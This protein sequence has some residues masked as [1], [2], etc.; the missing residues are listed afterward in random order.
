MRW[1]GSSAGTTGR[2]RPWPPLACL[3]SP[4]WP[5][6]D[7]PHR[8]N[9][10]LC[11]HC[12]V[13][14]STDGTPPG[15][16]AVV[17][18]PTPPLCGPGRA[19]WLSHPPLAGTRA[20]PPSAVVTMLS[21]AS[22][23]CRGCVTPAW[24]HSG[25]EVRATRRVRV[26]SRGNCPV[27][28]SGNLTVPDALAVPHP[29]S[30]E[31]CPE[32]AQT[33]RLAPPGAGGPAGGRVACPFPGCV[34]PRPGRSASSVGHPPFSQASHLAQG[35]PNCQNIPPPECHFRRPADIPA[36]EAPTRSS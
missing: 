26:R 23:T 15:H 22:H 2:S 35:A 19:V 7:G 14:P 4:A 6:P 11:G 9:Q 18:V 32:A 1:A 10:P 29:P 5:L 16:H 30:A 24:G 27:V 3:L 33:P 28:G 20:R 8:W 34:P 12:R 36:Q 21:L 17:R 25:M 31:P 13:T